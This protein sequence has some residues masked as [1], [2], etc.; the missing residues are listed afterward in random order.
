[1]C[2]GAFIGALQAGNGIEFGNSSANCKVDNCTIADIF[3]SGITPQTYDNNQ[4]ASGFTFTGNTI[5]KCGFAGIEI[6]VLSNGGKTSSSIVNILVTDNIISECGSGFSGIR[7]GSEGRGIKIAADS[8]AGIISGVA[9][10]TCCLE[11]NQTGIFVSGNTGNVL[12]NRTEFRSNGYGVAAYDLQPSTTLKI[13]VSSSLF[14]LNSIG[15]GYNVDNGSGSVF[16][17]YHNTFYD[18]GTVAL[19]VTSYKGAPVVKNNIFYASSDRI[20]IFQL[21][22]VIIT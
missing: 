20:Q 14:Y 21:L 19:S 17:L 5:S 15:F 9:V 2:G 13:K 8:G 10:N 16:E 22:L 4:S 11:S 1:M 7:Y 12:I 6:A 3:D 18:N